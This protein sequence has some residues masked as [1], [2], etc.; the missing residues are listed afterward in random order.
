MRA[1]P[2][3]SPAP[4]SQLQ[5]RLVKKEPPVVSA[6]VEPYLGRKRETGELIAFLREISAQH[7]D[8]HAEDVRPFVAGAGTPEAWQRF[9]DRHALAP[10]R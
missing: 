7:L 1:H 9:L 3:T 10:A 5:E 2:P 4:C 6:L 8:A